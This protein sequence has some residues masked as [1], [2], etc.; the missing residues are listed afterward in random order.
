MDDFSKATKGKDK[1]AWTCK[2]CDTARAKLYYAANKDKIKAQQKVCKYGLN[3]AKITEIL[4]TQ[5]GGCAICKVPLDGKT[6]VTAVH[7]DHDHSCCPGRNTC[8]KCVRG[9]LCNRCNSMLGY[10]LDD[11]SILRTGADYLEFYKLTLDVCSTAV[12]Y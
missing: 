1:R 3:A 6:R 2:L 8:G 4:N 10:T 7:V 11:P 12:I 9:L 5:G